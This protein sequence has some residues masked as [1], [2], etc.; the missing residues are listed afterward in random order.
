VALADALGASP[1]GL[2]V[3]ALEDTATLRS[4]AVAVALE[5]EPASPPQAEPQG[6]R[7][8]TSAAR[9]RRS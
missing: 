9:D 5:A 6:R 7:A 1:V 2:A 8:T 3:A 4:G